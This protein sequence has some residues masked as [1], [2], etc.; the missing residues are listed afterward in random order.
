MKADSP[1]SDN[2]LGEFPCK[3]LRAFRS[4]LNNFA[5]CSARAFGALC[6][7]LRYSSALAEEM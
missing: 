6:I 2:L 3:E 1:T 4:A 7:I 5:D